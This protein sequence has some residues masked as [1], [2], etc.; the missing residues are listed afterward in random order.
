MSVLVRPDYISVENE[1]QNE[2]QKRQTRK[3][4]LDDLHSADV[5]VKLVDVM[6]TEVADTETTMSVMNSVNWT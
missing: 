4:G 3:L 6:L 2:A 1:S 5:H